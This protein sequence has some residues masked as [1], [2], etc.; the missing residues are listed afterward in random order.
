MTIT[1][2]DICKKQINK[3]KSYYYLGDRENFNSHDIC[4]KC[5]KPLK[6]F[7]EKHKLINNRL[8]KR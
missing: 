3:E 4:D 6:L 5:G 8:K 1:K 2:C 7:L